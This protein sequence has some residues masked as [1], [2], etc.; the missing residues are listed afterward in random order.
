MSDLSVVENLCQTKRIPDT[1]DSLYFE[2]RAHKRASLYLASIKVTAW[3]LAVL[4]VSQESVCSCGVRFGHLFAVWPPPIVSFCFRV[5][6][7]NRESL[8]TAHNIILCNRK[9]TWEHT[10]L[11]FSVKQVVASF[12]VIFEKFKPGDFGEQMPQID[13]SAGSKILPGPYKCAPAVSDIC[14]RN[15]IGNSAGQGFTPGSTK[16]PWKEKGVRTSSLSFSNK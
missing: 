2:C 9:H 12:S 6:C 15:E 11:I 16:G 4:D 3:Q 1:P 10:A 5:A 14:L 8:P 13:Q 7:L